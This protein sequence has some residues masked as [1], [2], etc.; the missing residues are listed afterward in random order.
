MLSRIGSNIPAPFT[1]C[2]A[3]IETRDYVLV[4]F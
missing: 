2:R 1:G 3:S 4:S